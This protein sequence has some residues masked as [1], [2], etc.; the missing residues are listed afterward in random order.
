[1][2]QHAS[3]EIQQKLLAMQ[4]HQQQ[5]MHKQQLEA[6]GKASPAPIKI[7]SPL[8]TVIIDK[9]KG[10]ALTPEQREDSQR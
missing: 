8:T 9:N 4:R 5:Q 2:N 7:A 3:P 6:E 10:K 1:M